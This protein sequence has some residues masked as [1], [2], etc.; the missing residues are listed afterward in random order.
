[1]QHVW[2]ALTENERS[3][4]MA[5]AKEVV[6]EQRAELRQQGYTRDDAC[7]L[8]IDVAAIARDLA[9][10]DS[11]EAKAQQ[12]NRRESAAAQ[13]QAA[14]DEQFAADADAYRR[15]FVR[16]ECGGDVHE[17]PFDE[18]TPRQVERARKAAEAVL[19]A[20]SPVGSHPAP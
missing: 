9:W 7:W 11:G 20:E 15:G 17:F 18:C 2:D 1:M 13:R 10:Q 19:P 14:V 5:D 8:E 16:I 4:Y 3:D 6:K 12:A